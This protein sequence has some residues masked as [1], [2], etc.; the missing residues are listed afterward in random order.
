MNVLMDNNTTQRL[1]FQLCNTATAD[2]DLGLALGLG[3]G[4]GIPF[5]A[6]LAFIFYL[7]YNQS[8]KQEQIPQPYDNGIRV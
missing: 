6:L 4:L 5:T 3:L 7:G 2:T 1:L 8:K